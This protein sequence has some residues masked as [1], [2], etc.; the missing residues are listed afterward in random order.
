MFVFKND[1][2][3][4]EKIKEIKMCCNCK[5]SEQ[6]FR[7]FFA[8]CKNPNTKCDLVEVDAIDGTL[9]YKSSRYRCYASCKSYVA[10]ENININGD[11][12]F[13][14]KKENEYNKLKNLLN[15]LKKF[16]T[17]EI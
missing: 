7:G 12:E 9:R 15:K 11:C 5:Y 2:N 17:Y 4:E 6:I 16:V 8:Y 10:C 3:L 13:F 1:E 14:E